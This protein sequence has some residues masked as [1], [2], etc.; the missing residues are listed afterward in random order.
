MELTDLQLAWV[1]L[2][3]TLYMCGVIMLVQF[4]QY[5]L[6][7]LAGADGFSEY[8][9]KHQYWVTFVVGPAMLVEC[10]VALM[11][12]ALPTPLPSDLILI[13]AGLMIA[14]L[15]ATAVLSVPCHAQLVKGYDARVIRRLVLGN[16]PRTVFWIAKAYVAVQILHMIYTGNL[17]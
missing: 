1:N 11:W 7:R 16:W 12:L 3:A 2:I 5:P 10:G 13:N 14:I 6:F 15:A 17:P 8:A 9:T 4:A